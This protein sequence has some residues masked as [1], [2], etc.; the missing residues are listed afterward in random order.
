[1]WKDSSA[2]D[3]DGKLEGHRK[4][5]DGLVLLR[6]PADMVSLGTCRATTGGK[7]SIAD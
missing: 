4:V 1:M 6:M 2:D 5:T 3:S 7:D